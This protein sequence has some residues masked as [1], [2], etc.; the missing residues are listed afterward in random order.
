VDPRNN[1]TK[2]KG[3]TTEGMDVAGVV[4]GWWRYVG[5]LADVDG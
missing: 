4:R 5:G 2:L 3:F 1:N